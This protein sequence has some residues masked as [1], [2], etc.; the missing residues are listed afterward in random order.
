MRNHDLFIQ[1]SNYPR[2]LIRAD[3]SRGNFVFCGVH[4]LG[5]VVAWM[6]LDF[7]TVIGA[8]GIGVDTR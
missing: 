8:T 1:T 5:Y 3:G 6:G 4:T 2:R 7:I